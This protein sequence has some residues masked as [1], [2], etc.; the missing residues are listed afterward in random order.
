MEN[1]MKHFARTIALIAGIALV[2]AAMAEPA[3]GGVDVTAEVTQ[4]HAIDVTTGAAWTPT[5]W[6]QGAND[7]TAH[8]VVLTYSTNAVGA[9]KT[10]TITV[11]ADAWSFNTDQ[12]GSHAGAWPLLKIAN[13]AEITGGD[14]AGSYVLEGAG[15]A[16]LISADNTASSAANLVTGITNVAGATAS[17]S[18]TLEMA[19][20]IDAGTYTTGL[21]FTLTAPA[22]AS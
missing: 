21:T 7:P 3:T 8:D 16:T 22:S 13:G 12:N 5:A 19:D 17:F 18:L 6:E 4:T 11:V 14:A 1:M 2:S 15:T 20:T 10:S 9:D